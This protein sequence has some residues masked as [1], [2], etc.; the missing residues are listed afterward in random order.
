M[1]SHTS[2]MRERGSARTTH[3]LARFGLVIAAP[4]MAGAALARL[5]SRRRRGSRLSQFRLHFVP[6]LLRHLVARFDFQ[7]LFELVDRKLRIIEDRVPPGVNGALIV[8][9]SE[10]G[11]AGIGKLPGVGR[12][13]G[14]ILSGQVAGGK[15]HG[16]GVKA[17]VGAGP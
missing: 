13:T 14:L 15:S 12:E 17:G 3:P 5:C 9:R 16:I 4:G 1:H 7:A 2:P 6:K 8:A 10:G 11:F